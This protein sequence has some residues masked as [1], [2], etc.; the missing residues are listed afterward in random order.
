M[1][2][3][4][5]LC[6]VGVRACCVHVRVHTRRHVSAR[7]S[8]MERCEI[9]LASVTSVLA[10]PSQD[11][12]SSD[13][14]GCVSGGGDLEGGDEAAATGNR[15]SSGQAAAGTELFSADQHPTTAAFLEPSEA[16]PWHGVALGHASP[17]G[18]HGLCESASVGN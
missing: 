10:S 6:V 9:I 12:D 15:P 4:A 18:M 5:L 17:V 7:V 11:A 16:G 14:S 1:C 13:A 3:R 8:K 2:I